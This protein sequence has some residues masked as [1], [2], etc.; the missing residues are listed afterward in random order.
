M[1]LVAS[2]LKAS[3]VFIEIT[4]LIVVLLTVYI[5]YYIL[6]QLSTLSWYKLTMVF[7]GYTVHFSCPILINFSQ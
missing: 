1:I 5:L 6:S 4:E 7:I 2:V 3:I